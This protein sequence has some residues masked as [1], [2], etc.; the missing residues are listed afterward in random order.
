MP[1]AA[2]DAAQDPP[3]P[4]AAA[5]ILHLGGAHLGHEVPA[6]DEW[7]GEQA[8][9]AVRAELLSAK[10]GTLE[11]HLLALRRGVPAAPLFADDTHEASIG[12]AAARAFGVTSTGGVLHEL[13]RRLVT[14]WDHR[15][16]RMVATVRATFGDAIQQRVNALRR[17]SV[18]QVSR[19]VPC[20]PC[21]L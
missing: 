1:A 3:D 19:S 15:K 4:N 8:A 16:E 5:I 6:V 13:L 20:S 17:L 11:A 2:A 7:A 21:V 14:I 18:V 12:V 10:H 9:A